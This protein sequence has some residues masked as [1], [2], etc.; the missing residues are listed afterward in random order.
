LQQNLARR[1]STFGHAPGVRGIAGPQRL[2]TRGRLESLGTARARW[3]GV[4]AFPE[5]RG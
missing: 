2:P 3:K 4:A 5:T 1:W